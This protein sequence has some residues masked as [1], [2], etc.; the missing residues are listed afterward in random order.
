MVH[1]P[2][3]RSTDYQ[4]AATMNNAT[5]LAYTMFALFSFL[6]DAANPTDW[7]PL[8]GTP[9]ADVWQGKTAG[10]VA[11]ENVALDP[12][13]DK[14]LSVKPGKGIFVNSGRGAR[15]LLTKES[16]SDVEVHL[17][18]LIP[19]GSNSGV[20]FH[21]LYEI[22]ICDSF[23]V[24]KPGGDD[25]GGIYPRAE[26]TPKY[27]YLDKGVPPLTNACK[28]AGE[29]QTLTAIFLAPRFDAAGKKIANARI[30]QAK[31]NGKIIHKN[32]EMK[33]PTG[34]N[35]TKKEIAKGPLLLQGD[36]GPVAFRN[37]KIRAYKAG[38]RP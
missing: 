18:F 7:K 11:A 34:H 4:D 37:V 20:K 23:G 6:A 1:N 30:V 13:N 15:D 28:P 17:D 33:T 12:K 29:W 8:T 31:L 22:Q 24:K 2:S 27:R 25:C 38:E 3:I 32:V 35:W 10:W 9:A 16:F 19:K 26:L 5:P 21:G 36:H 14:K